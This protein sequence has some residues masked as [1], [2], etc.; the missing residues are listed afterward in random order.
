MVEE[1]ARLQLETAKAL[2]AAVGQAES[3]LHKE[4]REKHKKSQQQKRE[5]AAEADKLAK[6]VGSHL[7]LRQQRRC[8]SALKATVTAN[9]LPCS[10]SEHIW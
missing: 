1:E 3:R 2:V 4:N 6:L 9:R 5:E 7:A 10:I 8:S